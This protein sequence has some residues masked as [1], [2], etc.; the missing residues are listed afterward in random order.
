LYQN[1]VNS[2]QNIVSVEPFNVSSTFF[3]LERQEHYQ[4]KDSTPARNLTSALHRI[5]LKKITNPMKILSNISVVEVRFMKTLDE[6]RKIEVLQG[7]AGDNYAQVIVLADGIAQIK[8]GGTHNATALKLCKAL[9]KTRQIA[10]HNNDNKED[11][12]NDNNS[13][14]HSWRC[15][16]VQQKQISGYQKCCHCYKRG[17]RSF[18]CCYKKKKGGSEKASAAAESSIKKSRSKCSH[19]SRTSHSESN[20]WKKYPHKAPSKS[21]TKAS[22][23]FLEKELL[24]CSIKVNDTYY[25]STENVKNTYY[26]VPITED[27]K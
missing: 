12:D 3:C 14:Q 20:C 16:W 6:E 4:P 1:I 7:C 21:S 11:D 27:G 17:C 22:G 26:C 10:G 25:V 13:K 19:C 18:L 15:C 9:K 24:M 5:K 23:A 2:S 8:S